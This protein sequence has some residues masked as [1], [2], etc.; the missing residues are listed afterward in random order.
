MVN[1]K[2]LIS[3]HPDLLSVVDS[4]VSKLGISRS[5]VVTYAIWT[6]YKLLKEGKS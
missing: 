3:L 6:Y 2:V 1:K 5:A 4:I